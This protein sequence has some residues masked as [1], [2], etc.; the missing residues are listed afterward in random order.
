[1]TSSPRRGALASGIA[2]LSN[3]RL[4][5]LLLTA[6]LLPGLL[7][8]SSLWP[9]LRDGL[10]G[11]LA[12]DHILANDPL[13]APADVFDFVH[14]KAAAIRGA[15]NAAWIAALLGVLVQIFFAGGFVRCLG[16]PAGARVGVLEF[17]DGSRRDF[18]HNLKCFALFALAA[19]ITIGLWVAGMRALGRKLFENA[20]PGSGAFLFNVA[21]LLGALLL[22]AAL[23]L[24]HDFARAARRIAPGIGA[25]RGFG[26]AHRRLSGRR[27]RALG[28]FLFW[29]LLGGLVFLLLFSL[30]WTIP[31]TT[32]AGTLALFG[33]QL[34]TL[35]VR[36]FVRVGA[37]GSYLA[38]LDQASSSPGPVAV[39]VPLE[40]PV[41]ARETG[42]LPAEPADPSGS[43]YPG[44]IEGRDLR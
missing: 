25:W 11:T 42:P 44:N 4:A 41:L 38:L 27:V 35:S 18:W 30:G 23:S 34:A 32:A 1:M 12:G 21:R 7:V 14:D 3:W 43:D 40:P 39:S 37:W 2:A 19:A 31:A 6:T 16:R 20:A 15:W 29:L 33:I 5:A 8:A 28:L 10:G 13:L 26:F 22:Y 24:W 17:L 36:P 9:A